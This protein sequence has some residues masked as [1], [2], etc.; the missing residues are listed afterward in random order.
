MLAKMMDIN[1]N[2]RCIIDIYV[3]IKINNMCSHDKY[4][5]S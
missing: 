5:I 4:Y 2:K 3:L 1:Y